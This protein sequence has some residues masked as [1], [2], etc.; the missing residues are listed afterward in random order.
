MVKE[1]EL[2]NLYLRYAFQLVN[3]IELTL[4]ID[5]TSDMVGNGVRP[6]E[7]LGEIIGSLENRF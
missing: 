2:K 6:E 4:R 3:E 1:V 5:K 7:R